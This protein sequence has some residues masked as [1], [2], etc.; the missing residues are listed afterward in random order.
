MSNKKTVAIVVLLG[1]VGVQQWWLHRPASSAESAQAT[2]TAVDNID[3]E[4]DQRR[5]QRPDRQ[6]DRNLAQAD[7]AERLARIDAR[8][9]SLE[10]DKTST[11]T[12]SQPSVV[13]GSPEATAADRKIAALLPRGPMT[14]AQLF[15]LQSQLAQYNGDERVQLSAALARAINNGRV[16]IASAP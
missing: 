10:N 1:V 14:Q 5:D 7:M 2:P 12:P 8:L 15:E 9:A 16:Q 3:R 11:P 13:L 6:P 4:P